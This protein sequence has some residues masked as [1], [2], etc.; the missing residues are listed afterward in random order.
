MF[1]G[2]SPAD[3]DAQEAAGIDRLG[4]IDRWNGYRHTPFY[5]G[6]CGE[7]FGSAGELWPPGQED[8]DNVALFSTDL[9]R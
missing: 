8:A 6:D 9:C 3:G 2:T 7:V 4:V 5:R 1:T